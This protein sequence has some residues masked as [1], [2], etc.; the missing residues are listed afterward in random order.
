MKQGAEPPLPHFVS[1]DCRHV[2]V[3]V[4]G[5]DHERQVKLASKR[6]MPPKD[7]LS[8][9]ARCAVVVIIETRLAD[10][11]A[12]WMLGEGAHGGEILRVVRRPPRA[13]ACRR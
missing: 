12:F 1:Q 9:I 6:D 5:M 3:G 13:D 2:G 11:D 7:P 4:A 8:N 10:P